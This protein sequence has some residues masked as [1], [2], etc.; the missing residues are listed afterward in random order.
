MSNVQ[1]E[2]P[3][4]TNNNPEGASTVRTDNNN[5]RSNTRN[6]TNTHNGNEHTWSGD[7]PEVGAVL[8]MRTEWLD[9]KVSFRQF[10][11]KMTE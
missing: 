5:R 2:T 1:T 4:D 9:K 10:L 3:T 6:H 8:G 11:E 7:K